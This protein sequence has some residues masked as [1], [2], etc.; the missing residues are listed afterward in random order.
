ME[1]VLMAEYTGGNRPWIP[2]RFL[3]LRRFM[4]VITVGD[5][6]TNVI[7]LSIQLQTMEGDKN[8]FVNAE[9]S[10]D[11]EVAVFRSTGIEAL[12]AAF[13][14]ADGGA[15]SLLSTTANARVF[16]RTDATGLLELNLTDVAGGSGAT[17]YVK[18]T[19]LN[20]PGFPGYATATFD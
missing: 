14:L 7:P 16:A 11:V 15:G 9:E 10:V 13:T 8:P 2:E 20:R 19:P 12:A 18:I 6:D 17:V 5:E 3:I 4:P 1:E